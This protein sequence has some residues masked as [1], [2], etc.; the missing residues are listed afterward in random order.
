MDKL[1]SSLENKE[2]V[3]AIFLDFSKAFGAVDH[4]ILSQSCPIME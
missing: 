4:M 1:I 2:S 3:I